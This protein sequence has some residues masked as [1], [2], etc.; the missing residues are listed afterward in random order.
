MI[1]RELHRQC[2]TASNLGAIFGV[3]EYHDEFEVWEAKKGTLPPAEPKPH[4]EMGKDIEES[5][6][7][8]SYKRLT[9]RPA[10]WC[11]ETHQHPTKKWMAATPDALVAYQR[12]V[13]D[14]K[15][16]FWQKRR[17]WGAT[18]DD[19]PKR[20]QLQMWWT[21]DVLEYEVAD[22]IAWTG[23]ETPRIYEI[24]RDREVE[25]VI[26]ARA[27]EWYRRYVLG[28]EIPPLG[29]SDTAAR[30][31]Q[32]AF[33]NHKRPDLREASKEEIALLTEYTLLRAAQRGL[34]KRRNEIETLLKK[35]I[36]HREGLT[37]TN[38]KFTW[39]RVS[40]SHSIDWHSMALALL[41]NYIK[42]EKAR[43]ELID[44]YTYTKAGTRRICF[45]SDEEETNDR[46]DTTA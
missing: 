8:K 38:G 43:E 11:D 36:A 46:D 18:A 22:V 7:T 21:L 44:Q 19:I 45:D 25:R 28:D 30:W 42:E 23:E 33:P 34:I 14:A 26:E 13:V 9:G 35:A 17:Q 6:A 15:L 12:R 27:Y 16:V 1:N 24:V 2:I 29:A 39:R 4:M 5:L 37:W 41:N 3:D 32:Q 10:V 20:I 31:L 40:D